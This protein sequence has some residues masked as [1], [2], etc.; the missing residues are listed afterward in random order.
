MALEEEKTQ[1][2]L[3]LQSQ[4]SVASHSHLEIDRQRSHLRQFQHDQDKLLQYSQAL[5]LAFN[6]VVAENQWQKQVIQEAKARDIQ[7]AARVEQT[8]RRLDLI[9]R[10]WTEA[11]G[12]YDPAL[13]APVKP[14][15]TTTTT[16]AILFGDDDIGGHRTDTLLMHCQKLLSR[17]QY[18]VLLLSIV[19]Y[20]WGTFGTVVDYNICFYLCVGID[21]KSYIAGNSVLKLMCD[22]CWHWWRNWK[23]ICRI[24]KRVMMM[25]MM[26][27][28]TTKISQ[29]RATIVVINA[30]PRAGVVLPEEI[31]VEEEE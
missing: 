10:A 15:A 23:K 21:W 29:H 12:A 6:E 18:V 8:D 26:M 28:T 22:S 7:W 16:T 20:S 11:L 2:V 19:L 14:D 31:E 24:I 17:T 25:T 9:T 13:L 27:M 4:R 3:A 5:E 1:W 30:L